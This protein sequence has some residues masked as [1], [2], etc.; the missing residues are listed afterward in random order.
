MNTLGYVSY[1]QGK[2]AQDEAPLSQALKIPRRVLGPDHRDT[3]R[4]L[5]NLA[6]RYITEGKY[7][8]LD[9]LLLTARKRSE[10]FGFAK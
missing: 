8:A 10:R 6:N 3:R 4:C 7:S 1:E 2:Y 5:A 9:A